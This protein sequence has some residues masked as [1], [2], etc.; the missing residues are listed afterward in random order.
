M[1]LRR[2]ALLLAVFALTL[3]T[4]AHA[5]AACWGDTTGSRMGNAAAWSIGVMVIIVFLM[6]GAITGFGFYLR[7]RALHPLPDYSELLEEPS[8]THPA[9]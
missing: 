8:A 1:N 4:H 5:C 7:W 2:L 9:P 3:P 6:L